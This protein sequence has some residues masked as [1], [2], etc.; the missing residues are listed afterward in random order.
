MLMN[1][2]KSILLISSISVLTFSCGSDSTK[3]GDGDDSTAALTEIKN[4]PADET[5]ICLW[6]S[7]ILRES[8]DAK[9][10][11]KSTIYLGEKTIFLKETVI[12]STDKKNKKEYIKIKLTDG[13]QGWV[14]SNFMAVGS[15]AYA[16]KEKTKLYKRPDIL[17]AGKDEFDRMQFVVAVEDQ[18]DWIKV[19]GKKTTGKWFTEGWIKSDK[20]TAAETDVTVAILV[21]R[22]KSKET[23]EKKLE[24]LNEIS[25]NSDLSSSVFIGDVQN[26]IQ[27]INENGNNPANEEVEEY[28]EGD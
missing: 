9:G 21:E 13:S 8:P 11:Y 14:Q 2:F 24:A 26:M 22:A 25:S 3:D 19:K 15:K 18:G 12:D 17:S 10:K 20:L 28:Y 23:K 1:Y 16:L 7:L 5:A 6:S 27:E 4:A